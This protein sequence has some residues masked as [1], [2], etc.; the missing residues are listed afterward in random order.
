MVTRILWAAEASPLPEQQAWLEKEFGE[1]T[2]VSFLRPHVSAEY[3]ADLRRTG[4]CTE[5]VLTAPLNVLSKLTQMGIYPLMSEFQPPS[6]TESLASA[7]TEMTGAESPAP[8]FI[9]FRRLEA[10]ELVFKDFE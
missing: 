7:A 5:V 2:L 10:V 6:A 4:E 9:R 1:I 3:I 8:R